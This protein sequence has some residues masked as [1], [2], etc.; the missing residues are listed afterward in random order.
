M[1]A[2]SNHNWDYALEEGV[3][4]CVLEPSSGGLLRTPD[5]RSIVNMSS[6]SYLGL[7]EH[8]KIIAAAA[9]AVQRTGVL[10]SSLSRVRMAMPLL[11][12]AEAELSDLFDA[13]TGTINSC[14]AAAWATLPVLA[15]GLLTGENPPVVVF[16]KRAHFCMLAL[17]AA[18]ADETQVMTVP[19]NDMEALEEICREH[20]AVAYICDSVYSTG[21][22]VAPIRELMRLQAEYGLFL[23]FDEA[24]STVVGANGRGHALPALPHG[25]VDSLSHMRHWHPGVVQEVAPTG[26]LDLGPG[27]IEPGLLPVQWESSESASDSAPLAR[28]VA[29]E[30]SD[31]E[32]SPVWSGSG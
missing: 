26:V 8:P 12:E 31:V 5:D 19:H 4:G 6:Y 14:A 9:A 2:L 18:C 27:Y 22:T 23:Y 29:S 1:Q 11:E 32:F 15:S 25:P 21:G 16:D 30:V 10:N 3:H 17:K 20:E 28:L 7:D 24:H 13:D